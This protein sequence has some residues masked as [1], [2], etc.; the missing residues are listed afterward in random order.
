LRLLV[1]RR[2]GRRW[3]RSERVVGVGG[4]VLRQRQAQGLAEER[5]LA[6]APHP[7][8]LP[9]A[10]RRLAGKSLARRA[11]QPLSR[12]GASRWQMP[13][14][15]HAAWPW[16][17]AACMLC[18][19]Q[20]LTSHRML[21]GRLVG[22]AA[23]SMPVSGRLA[24]S[25][26]NPRP[27]HRCPPAHLPTCP[28]APYSECGGGRRSVAKGEQAAEVWGSGHVQ[29]GGTEVEGVGHDV[30]RAVAGHAILQ[31]PALPRQPPA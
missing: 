10:T 21:A 17:H 25:N 8:T 30:A 29:G 1:L 11:E 26:S 2:V 31:V 9:S 27:N 24:H 14:H 23:G 19:L 16:P 5:P 28:G 7:D 6:A 13:H 20:S 22:W 15:H 4:S 12:A 3:G 18:H